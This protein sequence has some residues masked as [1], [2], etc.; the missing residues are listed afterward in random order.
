MKDE[1]LTP[2][3]AIRIKCLECAGN[4]PSLVRRCDS[5]GCPL[6]TYRLG[7]NPKRAGIGGKTSHSTQESHTQVGVLEG[8]SDR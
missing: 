8:N 5:Q 1:T 3:R 4:K 6:H 2:I 7:R